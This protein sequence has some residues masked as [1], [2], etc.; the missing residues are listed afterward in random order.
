MRR[1][2]LVRRDTDDETSF[3]PDSLN[4]PF[5][6]S[7]DAPRSINLLQ[8]GENSAKLVDNSLEVGPKLLLLSDADAQRL[9]N[10]DSEVRALPEE[11]YFI[12]QPLNE[13]VFQGTTKAIQ[14]TTKQLRFRVLEDGIGSPIMG[15]KVIAYTDYR[16]RMGAIG[17]TD[18]MGRAT[19]QSDTVEFERIVVKPSDPTTHWPGFFSGSVSGDEENSV[20]LTKMDLEHT[21]A[22]RQIYGTAQSM[23]GS[24]IKVGIIDSGCSQHP[25]IRNV[26]SRNT[27]TGEASNLVE[28]VSGHGTFVAGLVGSSPSGS[29]GISGLA[30]D[31]DIYS[32]RVLGSNAAGAT[33]YSIVKAILYALDDGCDVINLS[34]GDGPHSVIVDEA[35]TDAWNRGVP[36]VVAAGNSYGAGV[37]FPAAYRNSIAVTS[38]GIEGS[39][40]PLSSDTLEIARPPISTENPQEFFGLFSNVGNEVDF[41]APGIGIISTLPG[42]KYGP[43]SGTSVSAPV[44]TGLICRILNID[45]GI[46]SMP[47]SFLRSHA[48]KERLRQVSVIRGFGSIYEGNGMPRLNL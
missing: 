27:V 13:A 18:F 47:K 21:D 10:E 12:P 41:I 9:N 31:V 28:D 3:A 48:I 30:P 16:N 17:Q 42:G 40:P 33:N 7:T 4:L 29:S 2:I 15:A 25:G 46:R 8:L 6:S 43:A 23:L 39:F 38:L 19:I 37:S 11:S 5:H 35:V 34:F 20:H 45:E 1:Y 26:Q 24:G 32:Y 44:I 36:V 14:P 22:V